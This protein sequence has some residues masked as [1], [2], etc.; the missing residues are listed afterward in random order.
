MFELIVLI[1]LA[2][3]PHGP[4]EHLESV[5]SGEVIQGL[6]ACSRAATARAEALELASWPIRAVYCAPVT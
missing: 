1:C 5:Q 3:T 2:G 4:C 6:L